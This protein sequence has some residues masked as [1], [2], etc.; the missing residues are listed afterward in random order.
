M[1]WH[2]IVS[3]RLKQALPLYARQDSGIK[4]ATPLIPA[5]PRQPDPVTALAQGIQP[6]VGQVVQQAIAQDDAEEQRMAT[7]LQQRQ[8]QQ[9]EQIDSVKSRANTDKH[10]ARKLIKQS[11]GAT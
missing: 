1:R 7:A 8:A 11:Y 4:K 6:V 3:E 10:T 9:S 5:V 2:E